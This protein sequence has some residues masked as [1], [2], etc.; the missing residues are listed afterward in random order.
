MKHRC[1]ICGR[2]CFALS[3]FRN[4]W[5]YSYYIITLAINILQIIYIDTNAGSIQFF[6][7]S[8]TEYIV[9]LI[10]GSL[11]ILL[12]LVVVIY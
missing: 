8:S 1:C 6:D 2:L 3:N 9:E 10:L 4:L 11:L 5:Y 12:S 7:T